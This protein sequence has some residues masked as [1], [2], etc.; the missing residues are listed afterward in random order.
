[1]QFVN[2]GLIMNLLLVSAAWLIVSFAAKCCG[3]QRVRSMTSGMLIMGGLWT[4]MGL[5]WLA[6]NWPAPAD[7]PAHAYTA[8][9]ALYAIGLT[10]A[11]LVVWLFSVRRP[12]PAVERYRTRR[13]ERL[14]S[15][16]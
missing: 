5:Y 1:M 12:T 15:G 9:Y 14:H 10:Q 7:N 6:Q 2:S 16:H 3:T 11:T 8:T 4:I 13:N